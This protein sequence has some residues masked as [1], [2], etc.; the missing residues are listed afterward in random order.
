MKIGNPNQSRPKPE[1][2]F[3]SNEKDLIDSEITHLLKVGAIEP[4]VHFPDEYISTIFVRKNKSGK[5]HMI[6]KLKGLNKPN[7]KHH[8]KMDTLWSTVR[9]MIPNCFMASIDL[10]DA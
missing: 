8:F 1:I 5:Y 2:H 3:D 10:K 7:E 4:T 9:L 6:L